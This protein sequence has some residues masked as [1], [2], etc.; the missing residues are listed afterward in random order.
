L[1][2]NRSILIYGFDDTRKPLR[3]MITAFETLARTREWATRTYAVKVCRPTTLPRRSLAVT[4]TLAT[5]TADPRRNRILFGR[6]PE[7]WFE[8]F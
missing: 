2:G 7:R 5:V 1:L 3:D 8:G 6:N 4:V